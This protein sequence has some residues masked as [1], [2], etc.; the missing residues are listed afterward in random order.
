MLKDKTIVI[1][2]TGGIAIYKICDLVSRL[3]KLKANVHV[4]MTKSATKFVAPLTF[5]SLSQNYVVVD[6]FEEPKTWDIEHISL[7]K[8]A[9]LFLIAPATANVIGKIANGIADDM[10]TTTIMATQGIKLIAPAMNT[11]MYNNPIVQE[12]IAKLRSLG[13]GMIEPSAGRLACGDIGVG[14]L[15][16]NDLIMEAIKEALQP[17]EDYK[18]KN[19]LI[20]AG[21]TREWIDPVRYITNP[22]SGKMGYAIAQAA[23]KRG[24]RVTLISGP[25]SIEKPKGIAQFISVETAREM[26]EA[27]MEKA[28]EQDIIIKAAAVSDCRPKEVF[29]DK[30]KKENIQLTLELEPNPDILYELGKMKKENQIL[31]GFAAETQNPVEE[32]KKKIEKKNLDY[33]VVNDVTEEGAGF[34][35]ETNIVKIIGASYETHDYPQMEKIKLADC[36]LD[37]IS[38]KNGIQE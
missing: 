18:D 23:V 5:Q 2:V 33:I 3:K 30:V 37:R 14:K 8:K 35:S 29:K 1:G 24:A 34:Q 20:T 15:A 10:L 28:H 21:P 4:I 6:M 7:A 25:T 9:D 38:M 31:V 19:I 32:A 16:D 27:V 36:I 26:Y 13:Y 11:N 22:S 17:N 12:N